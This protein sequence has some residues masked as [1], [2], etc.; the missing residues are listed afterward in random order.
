[1]RDSPAPTSS[2]PSRR[3]VLRALVP[4]LTGLGATGCALSDRGSIVLGFIGTIKAYS[5]DH[6]RAGRDGAILAVEQIN[7]AG[8]V[9]G[10]RLELRVVDDEF[11]PDRA[12]EAVRSLARGGA[13]AII[14][15]M[16]SRMGEAVARAADAERIVVISPAVTASELAGRDDHFFRV[17]P[18]T[19]VEARALAARFAALRVSLV[20]IAKDISNIAHTGDFERAFQARF[21]ELGGTRGVTVDFDPA[22]ESSLSDVVQ[23]LPIATD[24]LEAVLLL[25]TPSNVAILA[26]VMR[27]R[28][29]N[30]LLGASEWAANSALI[31]LGGAAVEGLRVAKIYNDGA[32]DESTAAFRGAFLA[33]FYYDPSYSAACAYEAVRAAA[34]AL[35]HVAERE[36]LRQA[37]VAY[38]PYRG[39]QGFFSFDALGEVRRPISVFMVRDAAFVIDVAETGE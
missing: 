36:D 26:Q 12:A 5:G 8:G 9:G 39:V 1:M 10:R 21:T 33:R 24:Q 4:A 22:T 7:A 18:Q 20:H 14:G 31:A 16:T 38:G 19:E 29:D 23:R 32:R 28:L 13:A 2:G 6:D 30:R 15:P 34:E 27:R 17:H 25:S 37:L 35:P 3:T 11:S